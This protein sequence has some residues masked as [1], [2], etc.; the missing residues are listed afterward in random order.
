MKR[1]YQVISLINKSNNL[2]SDGYYE[3]T[4]TLRKFT[5]ADNRIYNVWI[6]DTKKV[7]AKQHPIPQMNVSSTTFLGNTLQDAFDEIEARLEVFD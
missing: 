1:K 2:R 5:D 6:V 3:D 4:A 7:G